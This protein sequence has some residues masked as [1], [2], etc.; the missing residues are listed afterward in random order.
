M[1]YLG[2]YYYKDIEECYVVNVV[3]LV[4]SFFGEFFLFFFDVFEDRV[5]LEVGMLLDEDEEVG[6]DDRIMFMF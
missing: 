5:Y 3:E 6:F 2:V 4:E 1:D